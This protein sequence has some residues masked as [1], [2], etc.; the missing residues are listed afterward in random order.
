MSKRSRDEDGDDEYISIS[1][2]DDDTTDGPE[3]KHKAKRR[4]PERLT[5]R[6][7][8]TRR[9]RPQEHSDNTVRAGEKRHDE[10]QPTTDR[11]SLELSAVLSDYAAGE[12]RGLEKVINKVKCT[13]T[14]PKPALKE[15][16]ERLATTPLPQSTNKEKMSEPEMKPLPKISAEGKPDEPKTNTLLSILSWPVKDDR[17]FEPI[18]EEAVSHYST[19]RE[20]RNWVFGVQDGA[21]YRRLTSRVL[22]SSCNR[23]TAETIAAN[24]ARIVNRWPGSLDTIST[25]GRGARESESPQAHLVVTALLREYGGTQIYAEPRLLHTRCA[26]VARFA[27]IDPS[28]GLSS[29]MA[30]EVSSKSVGDIN[31]PW[32][33]DH[34][35]FSKRP[36]GKSTIDPELVSTDNGDGTFTHQSVLPDYL[37]AREHDRP[38]LVQ[39]ERLARTLTVTMQGMVIDNASAQAMCSSLVE[40]WCDKT[41]CISSDQNNSRPTTQSVPPGRSGRDIFGGGPLFDVIRKL[42]SR[43][44]CMRLSPKA[45]GYFQPRLPG[46]WVNS[47]DLARTLPAME[48][49]TNTWLQSGDLKAAWLAAA[50][51][52]A[53]AR[54]DIAA[55]IPSTSTC[56]CTSVGLDQVKVHHCSK[57][58]TERLCADLVNSVYGLRMCRACD[59]KEKLNVGFAEQFTKAL[60]RVSHATECRRGKEAGVDSKANNYIR[61][62]LFEEHTKRFSNSSAAWNDG[63]RQKQQNLAVESEGGLIRNP[64]QPSPDAVFPYAPAATSLTHKIPRRH[65]AGNVELTSLALNLAKNVQLPAM[66]HILKWYTNEY[67][68]WQRGVKTDLEMRNTRTKMV[69]HSTTLRK[70]R[71]KANFQHAIRKKQPFNQQRFDRDKDEW[72]TGRLRQ[73]PGPWDEEN[74]LSTYRSNPWPA[75]VMSRVRTLI[76]ELEKEFGIQLPRGKEDDCPWFFDDETVPTGWCWR[77]CMIIISDRWRRVYAGCNGLDDTVDEPADILIEIIFISCVNICTPA[78]GFWSKGEKEHFKVKYAEFLG[79]PMNAAVMDPLCFS[80]SHRLHGQQMRTGWENG[81]TTLSGRSDARNNILVETRTSNYLKHNFAGDTYEMLKQMIR[82]I[83]LPV[84]WYDPDRKFMKVPAALVDKYAGV[85]KAEGWDLEDSISNPLT[86]GPVE[87]EDGVVGDEEVEGHVVE[88]EEVE[89][90]VE[91]DDDEDGT[92]YD[93]TEMDAAL[94]AAY[95]EEAV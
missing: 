82:E 62:Q 42:D 6:N 41:N 32:I 11:D 59:K 23:A 49:C 8:T 69:Q 20:M 64:N 17:K 78:D 1:N 81:A 79:L 19:P 14:L 68:L 3:M 53:S 83:K 76:D 21:T 57:C 72:L 54:L 13:K 61:A 26:L 86:T 2:N 29:E 30:Y 27:L 12:L 39:A 37:G 5:R 60:L 25:I 90:H 28:S 50:R 46:F 18:F 66:L 56:F 15:L 87:A 16:V 70:I 24:A 7:K 9:S 47:I 34:V 22:V 77:L 36:A 44:T 88:D 89:D 75:D 10:I 80:V 58:G 31:V 67:E 35:Q 95:H 73:E 33:A 85:A 71:V 51:A 48:A 4:L 91:D 94:R 65:C 74:Y 38:Q 43:Q 84:S 63:Y 52:I 45:A 93:D 40:L 55:K 92:D